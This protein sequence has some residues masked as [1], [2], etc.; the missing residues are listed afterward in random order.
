MP[1]PQSN[2]RHAPR[3]DWCAGRKVTEA[4]KAWLGQGRNDA[5][6]CP[7]RLGRHPSAATQ[8]QLAVTL[9][10]ITR[11]RKAWGRNRGTGRPRR[12]AWHKKSCAAG[13]SRPCHAF[14]V[15]CGRPRLRS[16]EATTRAPERR[17]CLA[18]ASAAPRA[19]AASRRRL[20]P[21]ASPRA[22]AASSLPSALCCAAVGER[23]TDGVR[24][25]RAS[26][27]DAAWPGGSPRHPGAVSGATRT[28]QGR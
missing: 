2:P 18:A 20:S 22:A 21:G 10:H 19:R 26:V 15:V 4:H 1:L 12:G 16:V 27:A 3:P 11:L 17:H 14:A 8:E 13:A 24:D 25:A 9:R 5:P 7:S 6:P 28:P 23:D